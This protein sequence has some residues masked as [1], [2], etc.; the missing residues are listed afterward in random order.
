M[1]PQF[2]FLRRVRIHGGECGAVA[3][4]LHHEVKGSSLYQADS[5]KAPESTIERK[6]MSTKT[7]LKRV[8]LVAV[9]ALGFGLLTS[10]APA[11][12]EAGVGSTISSVVVGTIPSARVGETVT[13]PVTVNLSAATGSSE[14]IVMA[15]KATAAPSTAGGQTATS[16]LSSAS[17]GAQQTTNAVRLYLSNSAVGNIGTVVTSGKTLTAANATATAL[18]TT[19]HVG[20]ASATTAGNLDAGCASGGCVPA[21]AIA[22]ANTSADSAIV[23]YVSFI[24]DVAG[25]YSFLVSATSFGGVGTPVHP[26]FIAGDTSAL[27]TVTT[28]GAPTAVTLTNIGG[29]TTHS[30][31]IGHGA[32]LRVNLTGGALTGDEAINVTSSA[33]YVSKA[34]VTGGAFDSVVPTASTTASLTKADF[35][36]GVAFVNVLP[37]AASQSI[38]V[39]A[40]GTGS[41]AAITTTASVASQAAAASWDFSTFAKRGGTAVTTGWDSATAGTTAVSTAIRTTATS[42]SIELTHAELTATGGASSGAVYYG[43]LGIV[44]TSGT[45]TGAPSGPTHALEYDKAVSATGSATT[46]ETYTVVT[47]TVAAGA[48]GFTFDPSGSTVGVMTVTRAASSTS[49]TTGSVAAQF[50]GLSASSIRAAAASSVTIQALVK[51]QFNLAMANNAVTVSI[52]GRNS[53]RP[54]ETLTT[55]S[56]GFITTTI[57]D[58]GTSSVSDTVT[59]T[60]TGGASTTAT[61]TWGAYTVGT[62]TVT[63][64]AGAAD[65]LAYKGSSTTTIST[66][67]AGPHGAA[68]SITATVKDA[69]G[70]VLA[71]VP[72]TFTVSKGLIRKTATIDYTTVYTGALGTAVTQVI[73]WVE[74]EQVITATAGGKTGTDY[75]TWTQKTA[76]SARSISGAA[77][78]NAV[79]ATVKDRFGNTVEGVTVTAKTSAGYFGTGV[80]STTGTTDVDGQVKFFVT[81]AAGSATVT[82]SLSKDT[83]T[84]SIDTAG[85]VGGTAVTAATAGTTIGT[86]ASLAAAGVNSVDV[87]L[88]VTDAAATAAEAAT[89]AANLAAEA[90]DAAT[91]AAEEARDAADAATAA[92][93]ELATQVATLMAALKAQITTLANTVAKIAKKVKA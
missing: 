21:S 41:L 17:T 9:S 18:S 40:E 70:M 15:V 83:Y 6:Q 43:N 11:N 81:G 10:T 13:V 52:A 75:I 34:T 36:N 63:G 61:I 58:S 47:L 56:N 32:L 54:S 8:A 39:T 76:T 25:S 2:K 38:V 30:G 80:N 91:V 55:D 93:E 19:V 68:V 57:T 77:S 26:A 62:V 28:G 64:G 46:G 35:V 12:A 89:D 7:T 49:T 50:G 90:A 53:A 84:Q 67:V 1:T 72:V 37:T 33:G 42:A 45:L 69:D 27:I 92:V 60:A 86:G 59:F 82:L 22:I 44:D 74:G 88:T 73:D 87:A 23:G 29:T 71:G 14:T 31:G 4:A 24:P 78:G 79:T 51:D 66:A 85:N 20:T 5:G 48:G 3:R 65:A 16:L